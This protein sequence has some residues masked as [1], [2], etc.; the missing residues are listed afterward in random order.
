M[1]KR[2][3]E[4]AMLAGHPDCWTVAELQAALFVANVVLHPHGANA[5]TPGEVWR[6][7]QPIS[8]EMRAAFSL[9]LEC[10]RQRAREEAI[11]TANDLTRRTL[12]DQIDRVAIGRT[13]VEFDLVRFTRRSFTP[14]LNPQL[15]AKIT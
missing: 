7:R 12:F 3:A 4:Q 2:T 1:K 6:Q 13:L 9:S 14:P 11:V 15:L 5:P 10:Q 8:P